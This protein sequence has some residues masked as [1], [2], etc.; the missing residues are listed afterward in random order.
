MERLNPFLLLTFADLKKYRY[1]YWCG[2]PALL[3]KPGWELDGDEVWQT[4]DEDSSEV[5]ENASLSSTCGV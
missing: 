4:L 5:R 3:Q 1:Y 2:F